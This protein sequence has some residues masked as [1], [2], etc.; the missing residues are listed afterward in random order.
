MTM[1]M[2]TTTAKIMQFFPHHLYIT[3]KVHSVFKGPTLFFFL[4]NPLT[5]C[6]WPPTAVTKLPEGKCE[7][8]D[9]FID[10]LT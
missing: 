9:Q 4:P 10:L 1:L 8:I 2:M 5:K 3:N 7:D 6:H